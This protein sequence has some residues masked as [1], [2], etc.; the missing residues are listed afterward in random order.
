MSLQQTIVADLTT[1][2]KAKDADRLSVLRMIKA[3]LMNRQI[4][5]GGEL[6][7]EEVAKAL[8]SLV[9]QRRDSV[10]QYEKAGRS[11]RPKKPPRSPLSKIICPKPPRPMKSRP[12]SPPRSLIHKR[13]P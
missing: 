4:E 12:P 6:P 9:K 8:Q 11:L 5:M 13:H 1:A 10:E 3:N 2:M 7:D